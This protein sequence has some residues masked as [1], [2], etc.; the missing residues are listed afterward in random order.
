M[1]KKDFNIFFSG[2]ISRSNEFIKNRLTDTSIEKLRLSEGIADYKDDP[3]IYM[4]IYM[5]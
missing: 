1:K 4:Y 5:L 3:Y 2:S